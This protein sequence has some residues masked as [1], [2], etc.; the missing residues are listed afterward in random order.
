MADID[1]SKIEA[2]IVGRIVALLHS[3]FVWSG[4]SVRGKGEMPGAQKAGCGC[5]KRRMARKGKSEEAS[6][7]VLP[8]DSSFPLRKLYRRD[9][10][11]ATVSCQAEVMHS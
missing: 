7:S 11:T 5:F 4:L 9:S 1:S 2:R 6:H 8:K 3:L 10:R